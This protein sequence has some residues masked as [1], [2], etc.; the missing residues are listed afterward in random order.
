MSDLAPETEPAPD[1][2]AA[3]HAG[4]REKYDDVALYDYEYRLRKSDIAFYRDLARQVA[5]REGTEATRILELGC[6][7]GRLLIPLARD[8]HEVWGIDRARPMLHY[9]LSQVHGTK[10]LNARARARVHILQG[11][12]RH[13]PLASATEV[14]AGERFPLITC[15][16]NAF[17]HL[18]TLA[19]VERFFAEVRRLLAPDGIFA[20]DISHPDPAWLS[21]D[22]RRRYARTRF[23]HPTTGE[24]LIYSTSH[25]YDPLT[26]IDRIRFFYEPA[27]PDGADGT[28]LKSAE[29]P[30]KRG[31]PPPPRTPPRTVQLTQRLFF[32]AEIEALLHYAGFQPF[33]HAGGF[34]GEPLTLVSVEQVICARVRER[35]SA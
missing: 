11:D 5:A 17:N 4:T 12:F 35:K 3:L 33:Y 28:T 21:R 1:W 27:D 23:R 14:A 31:D 10:R 13:V 2:Q 20:F 18:Y 32:P 19:D 8:G 26:Q 34:D 24:Q 25:E 15:P 22:P 29:K 6:G 16:F 7:S 30:Q 9:L